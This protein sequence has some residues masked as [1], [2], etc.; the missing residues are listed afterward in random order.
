M[1]PA[2]TLRPN[3]E[4]RKSAGLFSLWRLII[5]KTTVY[6]HPFS[7]QP[8]TPAV[9]MAVAR[10]IRMLGAASIVIC[11]FLIFQLNKGPTPLIGR[12][13]HR[14]FNGMKSDPLLERAWILPPFRCFSAVSCDSLVGIVLMGFLLQQP[15][16]LT[17]H[18]GVR[19]ITIMPPIARTQ[20]VLMRRSSPWCE[21]KKWMS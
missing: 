9:K 14:L 5:V 17:V 4:R 1:L 15:E 13:G 11:L 3:R 19:T 10:P 6:L 7:C 16:S 8:Y 21:T 20:L 18:Y 12:Q 2:P